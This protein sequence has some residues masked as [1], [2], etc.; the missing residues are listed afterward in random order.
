M[1]GKWLVRILT[2]AVWST[3]G[4][5]LS[6]WTLKLTSATTP[7]VSVSPIAST[8]PSAAPADLARAFGPPNPVGTAPQAAA[9]VASTPA[10]GARF[11]LVGVVATPAQSGVAL[12]SIESKPARPYPVGSRIEDAYTVKSVGPRWAKLV[13]ASKASSTI[14]LDLPKSADASR[15]PPAAAQ[16]PQNPKPEG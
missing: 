5:S 7:S 14:T 10:A 8:S 3:L 15:T 2:L 11:T 4:L 13:P 6:F 12:I 1:R 9:A 16:A